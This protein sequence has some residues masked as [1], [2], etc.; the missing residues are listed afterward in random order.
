M[1]NEGPISYFSEKFNYADMLF[2]W[3]VLVTVFIQRFE[4]VKTDD[5]VCKLLLC[6]CATCSIVKTFLFMRIFK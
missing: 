3:T 4:M 1:I 6:I 2:I 5:F